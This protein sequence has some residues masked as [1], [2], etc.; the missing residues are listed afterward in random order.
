M[1]SSDLLAEDFDSRRQA[2]VHSLRQAGDILLKA[3][4]RRERL[5]QEAKELRIPPGLLENEAAISQLHLQLGALQ[6]SLRVRPELEAQAR[7]QRTAAADL[8][9]ALRPDLNLEGVDTLRPLLNRRRL[10][11]QLAEQD[12]RLQQQIRQLAANEQKLLDRQETLRRQLKALQPLA[13]DGASLGLAIQAARRAGDLAE[14]LR[15]ARERER[16]QREGCARDLARQGRFAGSLEQLALLA[17]P[18]RAVLERFDSRFADLSQL[19]R[20]SARDLSETRQELE[21]AE[22]DLQA[23]MRAEAVPSLA[24]LEAARRHREQGWRRIRARL[25][26]GDPDASDRAYGEEIGRAHV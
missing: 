11:T 17:L 14:S 12:G 10:I 25:E 1:C 26:G 24:D 7:S 5:R 19:A 2:A 18:E 3:D 23:L 8:L 21:R 16:L 6:Q 9:R 13:G 4:A 15:V 20:D 22:H